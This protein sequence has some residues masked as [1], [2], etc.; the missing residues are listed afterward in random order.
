[1]FAR[2]VLIMFLAVA[3]FACE[4]TDH[5]NIDKWKNTSKGPDKLLKAVKDDGLDADLSAHAAQNLIS[6]GSDRE[7]REA[8]DGMSQQRRAAVI[9]KLAPRMWEIARIEREDALPLPGQTIAKDTLVFLRK[10]AD[11]TQKQQIDG[12]LIDWYGVMSY[13]ARAKAGAVLGAT[14]MRAVGPAGGAKLNRVLNAVIAAPGQDKTK[15]RISDELLLGMAAS[16]NPESVKYIL[17]V[18]KMDRGDPTLSKRA[19]RALYMAYVNPE[20]LFDLAD[21]AAL[22]PNLDALVAAA[23]DESMAG[24]AA[25]DAIELI[26]ATGTPHCLAPL[27]SMVKVPHPNPVFRYAIVHAALI[28]GGTTGVVEI[29][30]A[31]PDD[32]NYAGEDLRGAISGPIAKLTPADQVKTSL[33]ELLGDKA[34]LPRWV[35]IEA[36]AAMK[37]TEDTARIQALAGA[38]DKLTGYWGNNPEGKADPTLG[39]RAKEL[40]AQMGGGA[41]K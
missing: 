28:C 20:G 35:A 25:N 22:L 41:P 31:L 30:R 26:R 33:R 12:Y 13:E 39:Q 24:Q 14:V 29:V 8:F 40:A 7:V 16:G 6:I 1:M 38:K 19:M 2:A 36:L 27:V 9:G 34:K 17:D 10:Y 32:G 37:S 11:D 23:K 18:A 15:I 21:P 5:E 3:I 4:K